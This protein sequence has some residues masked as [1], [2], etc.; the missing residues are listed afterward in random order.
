[1]KKT[2]IALSLFL[3][4]SFLIGGLASHANALRV[5]SLHAYGDAFSIITDLTTEKVIHTEQQKAYLEYSGD[6]VSIPEENYPDGQK[7]LSDPLPVNLEWNFNVP[8]GKTISRYDVV[9]GKE[10][11]L[12]D[13]YALKGTTATSLNVYNSYL[14]ENYFKVVANYADGT[15]DESEIKSYKVEEVYPRNLRIEGMTNC[16]DMGGARELEN[17]GHIKQGL[18]FRTSATNN[19]A[20]GRGDVSDRLT[21]AG[22]E[23]LL[24]RLGCKT[25]INVNNSGGNDVG[26]QNFVDAYM[27]YDNGKHHMYRNTEPLK[28]ALH[29]LAKPENYPVFYHCRIGTDRTGFMAIMISALLGVSENDIYQDYLFSNFGNIQEKR[30][31]GE[32]AGR[33]NILKYMDDLKTYPGEKLQNKA[34]NFLLSIG[35]PAEELDSIIDILVEGNKPEGNHNH[36]EVIFAEDFTPDGTEMK[37]IPSSATGNASRAHPKQY[38]TLGEYTSVAME[39][40]PDYDGEAMV[41]A[42]LGST[43]SSSSKKVNE[44]ITL[45][46]DG[47]EIDIN[48]I[49]FADAG[50]GTGENRTYYA[51]VM[52]A[53]VNCVKGST[54]VEIT[55][56]A[57]NLNIGAVALIPVEKIED[58]IPDD[59]P[60]PSGDSS[61]STPSKPA[62]NKNGCGGSII[63]VSSLV[64]LLAIGGTSFFLIRRKEK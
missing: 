40:N 54:P 37:T 43:D 47:E 19:W 30:Y 24:T 57:N 31:I 59:N 33:D 21:D 22:K 42:Y 12:S 51:P 20:Y 25:E 5:K 16:R 46:F 3:A 41:L 27:Y 10:A 15:K 8:S 35:M 23:E 56:L 48:E 60:N 11:D 17:G 32:K 52:L 26:V 1:M 50:F 61:S 14:G 63:A 58:E 39:F 6:Y 4:S 36:Q 62:E 28:Q 9:V 7:H 49:T 29:A 38:F 45:T 34:Y 18:I 53:T 64:S 44:S 2:Q 55:G 13:G